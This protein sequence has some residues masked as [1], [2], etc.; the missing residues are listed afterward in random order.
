MQFNGGYESGSGWWALHQPGAVFLGILCVRI[1][2][3]PSF[4]GAHVPA[5]VADLKQPSRIVPV[6]LACPRLS[7]ANGTFRL[8][9][10]APW[11]FSLYMYSRPC[12]RRR[13]SDSSTTR[14]ENAY[15]RRHTDDQRLVQRLL[16]A[17]VG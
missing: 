5:H 8:R 11:F 2:T 3:V 15:D 14:S 12:H 1:R 4:P 16:R 7:D 6:F 10:A 13:L 17:L 9:R